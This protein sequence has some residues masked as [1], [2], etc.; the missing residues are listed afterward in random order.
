MK[1]YQLKSSKVEMKLNALSKY[2]AFDIALN[3]AAQKLYDQTPD[4]GVIP[5]EIKFRT[6]H[7]DL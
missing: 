1:H 6:E 3:E 4:D 2:Y 7:T 5:V